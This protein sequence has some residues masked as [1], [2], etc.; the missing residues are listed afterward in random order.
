MRFNV[1]A[2]KACISEKDSIERALISGRDLEETCL[3]HT[4]EVI[5]IKE[6]KVMYA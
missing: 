3:K 4:R 2:T 6:K 5:F 1:S